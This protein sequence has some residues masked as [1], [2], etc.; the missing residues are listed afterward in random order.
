MVGILVLPSFLGHFYPKSG[1]VIVQPYNL[2][3]LQALSQY[4]FT[5]LL[6]CNF[7]TSKP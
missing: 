4:N 3:T 7:V 1:D 2:A 6:P 5:T